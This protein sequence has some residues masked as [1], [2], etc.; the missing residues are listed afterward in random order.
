MR[1]VRPKVVAYE[2]GVSVR[3]VHRWCRLGYV[4][5]KA[6]AGG[7]GGYLVAVDSE[8]HPLDGEESD[9]SGDIHR[10]RG[11]FRTS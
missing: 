11:D 1:W 7:H 2:L 8:G 6:L 4:K 9:R 3:T 5:R 10:A